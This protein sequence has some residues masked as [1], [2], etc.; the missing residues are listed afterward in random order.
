[1]SLGY[2]LRLCLWLSTSGL[3]KTTL[4]SAEWAYALSTRR[5][6]ALHLLDRKLLRLTWDDNVAQEGKATW[7]REFKLSW[8]KA[9]LLKPFRGLSGLGPVGCQ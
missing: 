3:L 2:C 8:R 1:M 4:K 9:G 7:K 6:V 5:H